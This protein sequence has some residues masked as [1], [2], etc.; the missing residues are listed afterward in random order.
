MVEEKDNQPVIQARLDHQLR[1][2]F[3]VKWES[4]MYETESEILRHLIRQ[5]TY[6]KKYQRAGE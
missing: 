5:Y 6:G 3:R 1:Y 4:Q 2:D